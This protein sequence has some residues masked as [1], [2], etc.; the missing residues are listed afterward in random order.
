MGRQERGLSFKSE[1]ATLAASYMPVPVHI[2]GTKMRAFPEMRGSH[3]WIRN[4]VKMDGTPFSSTV[5]NDIMTSIK[6]DDLGDFSA[7]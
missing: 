7:S 4:D 1:E 5:N 2:I 6:A 3:K